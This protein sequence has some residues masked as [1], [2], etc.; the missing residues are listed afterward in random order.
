MCMVVVLI[1][2]TNA[3]AKDT[4]KVGTYQI[5]IMVE[6]PTEGAFIEI[7][8]TA[9]DRADIELSISVYPGKR[10]EQIFQ[11]RKIDMLFPALDVN[12]PDL[13]K[14]IRSKALID[15]KKDFAFVQKGKPIIKSISELKGMRVGL[16]RG[17]PYVKAFTNPTNFTVDWA[18]SEMKNI[19]KLAKGRIDVAI[20]DRRSAQQ[21]VASLGL[22]GK[23][24]HDPNAPLVEQ[25]VYFAFQ[26]ESKNKSIEEKFSKAVISMQ[27]DKTFDNI[28]QKH[29]E[30]ARIKDYEDKARRQELRSNK[31]QK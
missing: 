23:V 19:E 21:C 7:A 29:L 16:T 2:S 28:I 26:N 20:G 13:D 18:D 9:A 12:F 10:M 4:L 3:Y 22:E 5:P 24:V 6:S 11:S 25:E 17:F 1:I 30:A 15:I 8:R 31:I 14:I 27:E